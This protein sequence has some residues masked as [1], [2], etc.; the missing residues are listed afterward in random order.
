MSKNIRK[1]FLPLLCLV[2]VFCLIG[3]TACKKTETYTVTVAECEN[4]TVTSD[5]TEAAEGETVTLTVTPADGYELSVLKVNDSETEVSEGS[6]SFAMPAENVTVTAE[7]KKTGGSE[8][9]NPGDNP[10]DLEEGEYAV[11]LGSATGVT[12]TSDKQKGKEGDT[13][14]LTVKVDYG[15]TLT[16][17]KLNGSV[18]TVDNGGAQ[19]TMPAAEAKITVTSALADNL[20][21][22]AEGEGLTLESKIIRDT[23]TSVWNY[24]YKESSLDITVYVKDAK[25]NGELDS[26]EVYVGRFGYA[27]AKL[28]AYHFGVK[29]S[30]DGTVE[31]FRA[32]DGEYKPTE[33]YVTDG[34][35][36]TPGR[37]SAITVLSVNPWST[38]G[39]A[40]DGYVVKLFV[41]YAKLGIEGTA[42]DGTLCALPVLNNY[43]GT[44][45]ASTVYNGYEKTNAGAYPV[46]KGGKWEENYYVN[47]AGV[48]GGTTAIPAGDQWDLSKDYPAEDTENYENRKVVLSGHDNKDNNLVFFRN[49]GKNV[50][51]T[52]TFKA[53]GVIGDEKY[54]KFGL[55]LFD[56]NGLKS[57]L[58][59]YADAACNTNKEITGTSLGV[60]PGTS[61]YNWSDSSSTPGLFDSSKTITLSMAYVA[62][63][64]YAY[65]F[66]TPEGGEETLLTQVRFRTTKDVII[67]FK[68][69]AI[70]LEVTD[71]SCTNNLSEFEDKLPE[72]R[73]EGNTLGST[74]NYDYG[75]NWV[76][77]KDYAKD[78]DNYGERKVELTGHDGKDN[79]LYFKETEGKEAYVRATFKLTQAYAG[80]KWG[81]FGFMLFDNASYTGTFFYVDAWIGEANDGIFRGRQLG[82]NYAP[83]GWGTWNTLIKAGDVFDTNTK[84]IT[85]AMTY[86]DNVVSMYYENA[87]GDDILVNQ[88]VYAAHS[89]KFILG[90]KSFAYGMEVTDYYAITDKT[91]SEFIAHNPAIVKE[92][93]DVLVAGDSYTEFWMNY[94]V[95]NT[96]T[97]DLTSDGKKL[98]DVGV[99]GTQV[100]YWNNDGQIG[101]LTMSYN[102]ENIVFHIGVNDID[103]PANNETDEKNAQAVYDRLVSLFANYHK[104]FPE[105]NIF[106][107]SVIPNNFHIKHAGDTVTTYNAA[108]KL[109]NDKVKEFCDTLDYLNYIDQWTSFANEDGEIRANL[110]MNDGLHLNPVYGYPL[111]TANIKKALY[112]DVTADWDNEEYELGASGSRVPTPAWTYGQNDT[113]AQLDYTAGDYLSKVNTEENIYY[114]AAPAAQVLFEAEIR[115]KDLFNPGDAWSKVGVS[116]VNDDVTIFAY[117][118]TNGGGDGGNGTTLHYASLVARGNHRNN[119]NN[120]EWGLGVGDWNWNNQAG[121]VISERD[122]T[123][124]FSTIGIA[125]LGATIYLLVDG[126]VITSMDN[127]SEVTAESKFTAG[128]TTFS[129]NVEVKTVYH[130]SIASEV[131]L[132]VATPHDIVVP[133]YSANGVTVELNKTTAKKTEKI[134]F[135]IS[136]TEPDLLIDKVF[137]KVGEEEVELVAEDG[138]YSFDMPDAEVSIRL[139]FI[140]KVSIT[141]GDYDTQNYISISSLSVVAGKTVTFTPKYENIVIAYLY[142]AGADGVKHEIVPQDGVYMLEVNEDITVTGWTWRTENGIIF[143][144][145]LSENEGWTQEVLSK[146]AVENFQKS[147]IQVVGRT[148]EAGIQIGFIIKH[149]KPADAQIQGAEG[150]TGWHLSLNVEVRLNGDA[151]KPIQ[152]NFNYYTQNCTVG[153][154]SVQNT[155]DDGY[156]YLSVMEMVVPHSLFD[157]NSKSRVTMALGGVFGNRFTWLFNIDNVSFN[158]TITPEGLE[159]TEIPAVLDGKFDD[160]IWTEEVKAN[161][162]SAVALGARLSVMAVKATDGVMIGTTVEHTKEPFAVIQGTGEFWWNYMGPEFRLFNKTLQVAASC[163]GRTKYSSANYVSVKN[164]D[165]TYTTKFEIF[166]PYFSFKDVDTSGDIPFAMSGVYEVGYTTLFGS[167][168]NDDVVSYSPFFVTEH[169]LVRVPKNVGGANLDGKLDDA[170]W[171]EEIL[172]AEKTLNFDVN[173][174]KVSANGKKVEGGVL[175]GVKIDTNKS[176]TQ[177]QNENRTDWAAY[178]H[179]RL[180]LFAVAHTVYCPCPCLSTVFDNDGTNAQFGFFE[181]DNGEEAEYRYT[182]TYE[183]FIPFTSYEGLEGVDTSGNVALTL[184]VSTDEFGLTACGQ[185][186]GGSTNFF[187]IS[188]YFTD[189]GMIPA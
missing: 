189:N 25:V 106:W 64:G 70:T 91:D 9:D 81:K 18:L 93:I 184:I 104:A 26:V 150:D 151:A 143:D 51:A 77:D 105:A 172:S 187:Q 144:G 8:D 31:H 90:I 182:T 59:Y 124:Q 119:W 32:E 158:W 11:T 3:V 136:K 147:N 100:P 115:S 127:F 29:V 120:G 148:T 122:I 86:A 49:S 139:T 168:W 73:F 140:G 21:T 101:A 96:L 188:G 145:K 12:V 82:Y 42:E 54:G 154:S 118:E 62:E 66:Y 108:Y 98:A 161:T 36:Y 71:Y 109:L 111:W 185:T 179:L 61:D 30:A 165:G 107:V 15:Y 117:F 173:S 183:I 92:D 89:D 169:G 1:I 95:W 123:K 17:L 38:E 83:N 75:A 137:M 125:K 40:V 99:G 128:V 135:T 166:V 116:L 46:L 134:S 113:V 138:V 131:E 79:N 175:L 167:V 176:A 103:S 2:M 112:P 56:G 152:A 72:M 126:K 53:T 5:K 7:F 163:D 6:A 84:T 155:A 76:I 50:Y 47:G 58:M 37:E 52:A 28:G 141:P 45:G 10:P 4:G 60:V 23:A 80:E 132:A 130:T 121:S 164:A 87:N 133:D 20:V 174:S 160:D 102:P 48:L 35:E 19:F 170:V 34:G 65:F 85:L 57:G 129:R 180:N 43:T 67:G 27:Y 22:A 41:S 156:N 149:D 171:T 110:M 63:R 69:F 39:T 94:G 68:S 186:D 44:L 33:G 13:V 74:D 55:M 146:A 16:S 181:A 159:Y 142:Y 162:Y 14:N 97:Y 24:E 78:S 153:F 177:C 157:T 114:K 88:C 178:Q